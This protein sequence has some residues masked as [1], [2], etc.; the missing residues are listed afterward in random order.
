MIKY[1]R[2]FVHPFLLC[3][4]CFSGAFYLFICLFESHWKKFLFIVV[5]QAGEINGVFVCSGC[6]STLARE[7]MDSG[8]MWSLVECGII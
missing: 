1:Y 8:K 3:P 7:K 2:L 6:I 4:S 5:V